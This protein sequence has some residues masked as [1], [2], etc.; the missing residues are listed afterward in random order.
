MATL[1]AQSGLAIVTL[2]R[3]TRAST[4]A[5]QPIF[6]TWPSDQTADLVAA[7]TRTH[8]APPV[9]QVFQDENEAFQ[10]LRKG[11]TVDV[12]HPCADQFAHWR[13]AG[14]LQ[15][16]DTGRL[17]HWPDLFPALK[18]LPGVNESGQQW[19][20]PFDWGTT[21]V[22]Y[23]ADL[24]DIETESYDLLWAERYAGQLA[25]G[26]DATESVII[27][28][29]VAGVADPFN[30]TDDE[31]E[32]VRQLLLRQRRL[33]SFYWS[34]IEL[35]AEGLASGALVASTAWNEI[36]PLLQGRG[37]DIRYMN[38]KEGMLGWCCGLVL[39]RTA[40][41]IDLAY[42]LMNSL[43][44]PPTGRF[45]IETGTAHANRKVFETIDAETLAM[46]GLPNGPEDLLANSVF[47]R[48]S[49]RMAEY[50]RLFDEIIDDA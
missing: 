25:F 29:L 22:A 26:T 39:T 35:V 41:E 44:S 3:V 17:S 11:L 6:Y 20:V 13:A 5:A 19:F 21:S 8:D 15:P 37:L 47:L 38:P 42:E 32:R 49:P 34:D 4:S 46:L 31:L 23:R 16:I 36:I 18:S 27:A 40:T 50:Q 45:L 43:L 7:F 2:P 48:H 10:Q 9:V 12:A 28:G 24:V 33:L 30:M 14:L 1:L